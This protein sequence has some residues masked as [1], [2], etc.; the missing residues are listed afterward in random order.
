MMKETRRSRY[1]K[2]RAQMDGERVS[3]LSHWRDLGD[4]ILP[5]RP[6]FFTADANRGDRR[7]QRI[8]DSTATMAA[9]TLASGMTSGITSPARPWFKLTTPDPDAG[10]SAAVKKWLY[11]VQLRMN[12]VFSKSNLYETLPSLYADMGVFGTGCLF[13]EEDFDQVVRFYTVPIGSYW[14]ANDSRGRVSVFM[15]EFR[16]TVRQLVDKFGGGSIEGGR[17]SLLVKNAYEAGNLETWVDVVH[18]VMKNDD[19]DP[20][21]E[22]FSRFKKY[23]S[24]YYERSVGAQVVPPSE[25]TFLRESGYDHFP[26]F[27]TRWET[28]G[29]DIYGTNCPGMVALGDIKALQLM[30]KRKAQ[31]IDKMVN[32]PMVAPTA[33]RTEK[34]TI[35]PGEV[36]YQD[37]RDGQQG[38]RAAHEVNFRLDP[39]LVDIEAHQRRVNQAFFA[40]LFLMMAN[41]DRNE[42]ATATEITEK[43]EEKLLALGPVLEQLNE[44]LLAPLIDLV[45]GFMD[46]QGQIPAAPEQLQ[47]N[48]LKVEFIS[49]MAVAQKLIGV[50]GLERFQQFMLGQMQMDPTVL[51]TVDTSAMAASYADFTSVPPGIIRPLEAVAAIRDQ[52]AKQ[53]QA[54][55]MTEQAPALAGAAK[56]LAGADM[57]GDNALTR[58][59]GQAQAGALAPQA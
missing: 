6:R 17:F 52:K 5:R 35:L 49:I 48:E 18:L 34:L 47:G 44:A 13:V 50:S 12:T 9:R 7:N 38:I 25:D 59:L 55:A 8:I 40:D 53:A 54:Q 57:E 21:R 39:L 33:M 20:K 51:D 29:E 22:A 28:T 37:T 45:Y 16:M 10:E 1:E 3:F 2:L 36:N 42:R 15:R 43:R 27:V 11:D 58:L 56:S 23:S 24:C 26:V 19:H 32:P 46:K 30:H 31:A 4:F 41:D 14:I